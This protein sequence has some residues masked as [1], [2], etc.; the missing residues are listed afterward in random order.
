L[1]NAKESAFSGDVF[2]SVCKVI[3]ARYYKVES[4]S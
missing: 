4:T 2:Q 1:K 3:H